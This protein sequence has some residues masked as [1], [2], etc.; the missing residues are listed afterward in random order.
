MYVYSIKGERAR[1]V[2]RKVT[3]LNMCYYAE[4]R[5]AKPSDVYYLMIDGPALDP[6]LSEFEQFSKMTHF[7]VGMLVV[8]EPMHEDTV[9]LNYVAVNRSYERQ[10]IARRLLTSWLT[11][12]QSMCQTR[13][14]LWVHRS[15]PSDT[16]PEA[17]TTLVDT[18]CSQLGIPW[19]Q[20]R[21]DPYSGSRVTIKA[22][23]DG[24]QR[25]LLGEEAWAYA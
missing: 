1:N 4:P 15:S 6:T 21:R 16:A 25:Q 2:L 17:F 22:E 9:S 5:F 11:D 19:A 18:L 24:T 7:V 20:T 14:E 13:K 8:E 3:V 10:G 12:V 23:P